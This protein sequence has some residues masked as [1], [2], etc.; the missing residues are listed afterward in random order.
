LP[1]VLV[2]ALALEKLA[3]TEEKTQND[4][5]GEDDDERGGVNNRWRECHSF[6]T[7]AAPRSLV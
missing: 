1:I 3:E 2:L 7:W 6:L 5:E 4:D